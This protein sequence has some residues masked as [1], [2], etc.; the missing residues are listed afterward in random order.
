MAYAFNVI[1]SRNN[2]NGFASNV[3]NFVVT[4]WRGFLIRV[5]RMFCWIFSE[6]CY[7]IF[8]TDPNFFRVCQFLEF[9]PMLVSV[10]HFGKSANCN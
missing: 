6:A 9:P 5:N 2:L 1:D 4:T 3:R 7:L 8:L 10:C